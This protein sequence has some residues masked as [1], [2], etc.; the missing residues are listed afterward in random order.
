MGISDRETVE[1]IKENPY[2][3]YLIGEKSYRN[4]APFDAS[5]I[6]HFRQRIERSLIQKINQRIIQKGR[7]FNPESPTVKKSIGEE[8]TTQENRGKLLIDATVAPADIK[9]P[10]DV[11]MLNQARKTTQEIV[12]I[13]Y[14]S[15][16]GQLPE[17]PITYRKIARKE[18][19]K[20]AKKRRQSGKK[21]RKAV[22]KQLQYLNRNF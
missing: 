5:M 6:G 1:Q 7:E 4:E 16:K 9:Y 10:T 18:Y 8:R 12:D 11:E 22:K 3:Q 19:L 21:R 13:L 14:K 2:L 20:F 17:K 15:L